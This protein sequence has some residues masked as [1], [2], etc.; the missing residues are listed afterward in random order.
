VWMSYELTGLRE[1]EIRAL[2]S[3]IFQGEAPRLYWSRVRGG[4]MPTFIRSTSRRRSRRFI[5]IVDEEYDKAVA[6]GPPSSPAVF[7]PD[8]VDSP[9]A[10]PRGIAARPLLAAAG[11]VAVGALLTRRRR[12]GHRRGYRRRS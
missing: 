9:A 7:E 4:W 11:G 3:R 1:A 8:P 2:L 12:S 6:L 10:A 5:R